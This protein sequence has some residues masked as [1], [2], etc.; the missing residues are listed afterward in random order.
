MIRFFG[1]LSITNGVRYVLDIY[2]DFLAILFSMLENHRDD[3]TRIVAIETIGVI[4]STVEGKVLLYNEG[5]LVRL[6]LS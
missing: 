3:A 2:N 6:V 5:T 4:G 1:N